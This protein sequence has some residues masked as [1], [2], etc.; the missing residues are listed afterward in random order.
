MRYA[1]RLARYPG[2]GS[3]V[4]GRDSPLA[5]VTV[6]SEWGFLHA[7]TVLV[8]LGPGA[9][10]LAPRKREILELPGRSTR[11]WPGQSWAAVQAESHL[12]P[13]SKGSHGGCR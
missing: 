13:R 12:G 11:A 2:V 4:E 10:A 7:Y 3:E 8:L 6:V 1:R 5:E 9:L